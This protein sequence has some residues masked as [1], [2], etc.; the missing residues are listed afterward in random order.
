MTSVLA[1]QEK[2]KGILVAEI[3]EH[4]MATGS[5]LKIKHRKCS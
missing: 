1:L 2:L 5:I 4:Y 3:K